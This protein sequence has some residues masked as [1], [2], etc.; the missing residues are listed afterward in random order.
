MRKTLTTVLFVVLLA[1]WPSASPA[2]EAPTTPFGSEAGPNASGEIPAFQGV[3]GLKCP[4]GYQKGEYLPSPFR[5]EKPLFR[6]DHTNADKYRDR[7]SAGQVARLKKNTAYYMNVYPSHRI[8]QHPDKYLA[9]IAK[10]RETCKLDD[11]GVLQGFN[12]GIPFPA[13][14]SGLEAIWNVKKPWAGDDLITDDCRRVVSPSGKVRKMRW[15]VKIMAFDETRLSGA[16][17]NPD[18]PP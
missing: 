13:P 16:V 7:L 11:K 18:G 12:G 2:E 4:E 9:A 15:T 8:F 5:D 3:Q 14:K 1:A 6:I 17:P 10:N